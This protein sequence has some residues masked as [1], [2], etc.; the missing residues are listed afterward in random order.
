MNVLV[1]IIF[2][3]VGAGCLFG[4]P[5]IARQRVPM[6]FTATELGSPAYRRTRALRITALVLN[7]VLGAICICGGVLLLT[8]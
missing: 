4:A 7:I 8:R 3:V 6:N 2:V 5:W 1:G